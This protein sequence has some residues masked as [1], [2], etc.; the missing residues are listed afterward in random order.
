MLALKI[1][2]LAFLGTLAVALPLTGIPGHHLCFRFFRI[3]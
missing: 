2:V 1:L 3:N